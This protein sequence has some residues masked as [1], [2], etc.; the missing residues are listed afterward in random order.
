[1]VLGEET[2]KLSGAG[3]RAAEAG[4]SPACGHPAPLNP[5]HWDVATR[6]LVAVSGLGITILLGIAGIV[7][8]PGRLAFLDHAQRLILI[9]VTVGCCASCAVLVRRRGTVPDPIVLSMAATVGAAAT[10]AMVLGT[11]PT[12]WVADPI[13]PAATV[14]PSDPTTTVAGGGH[15]RGWN[16]VTATSPPA[17]PQPQAAPRLQAEQAPLPSSA[18]V[19]ATSSPS[20]APRSQA[21]P[22][23]DGQQRLIRDDGLTTTGSGWKPSTTGSGTCAPAADGLHL[24]ATDPGENHGCLTT[25]EVGAATVE[26]EFAFT[27]ARTAGLGLRHS[28]RGTSYTGTVTRAGRA[29]LRAVVAGVTGTDLISGAATRFSADGWHVIA[30][31]TAG[32]VLTVYLDHQRIGSTSV[33]PVADAFLIEAFLAG[34][35]ELDAA[36]TRTEALFRNLRV[37]TA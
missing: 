22:Y 33:G 14:T 37:W 23:L 11:H 31:T 8:T 18:A 1:M 28:D 32:G 15:P 2:R 4:A 21:N 24:V 30:M 17:R 26:I 35:R 7:P 6:C 34:G 10:M 20:P 5:A 36:V 9:G 3:D 19:V 13:R 16:G 27:T 29:S 25:T 12:S